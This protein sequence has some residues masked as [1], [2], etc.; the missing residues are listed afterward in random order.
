MMPFGLSVAAAGSPLGRSTC[1]ADSIVT[2]V[3]T[4]KMI[5]RTR[6]I[7]VNGVMLMSENTAPPPPCFF[8]IIAMGRH[9]QGWRLS[10][11]YRSL[12]STRTRGIAH[13]RA[14]SPLGRDCD[15]RRTGALGDIQNPNHV[16]EQHFAIALE[17]H[18][19]L[20]H[21]AQRLGQAR[22]KFALGHV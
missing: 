15:L 14:R 21:L 20:V 13:L 1:A 9:L 11:F 12:S 7:S 17:H 8:F 6:K 3:V 2:A 10:V 19:L 4:M 16:A 22:M 18:D 5:S